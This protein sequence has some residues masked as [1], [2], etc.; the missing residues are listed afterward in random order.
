MMVTSSLHV[1]QSCPNDGSQTVLSFVTD[2]FSP[3]SLIGPSCTTSGQTAVVS[4]VRQHGVGDVSKKGKKIV[5]PSCHCPQ[6]WRRSCR[7][8]VMR[9]CVGWRRVGG[10]F[11]G[12]GSVANEV[13][14]DL[15]QRTHGE[16][17][18]V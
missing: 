12:K 2:F 8:E 1:L 5:W 14:I 6:R 13:S 7:E 3:R 9:V 4:E 15:G 16:R 11:G 17:E 18:K 10:R